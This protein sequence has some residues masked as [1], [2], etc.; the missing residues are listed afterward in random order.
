MNITIYLASAYGNDR[1][2]TEG[3]RQLGKWI[4]EN[5]HTLVYGGSKRGLM[6]EAAESVLDAGGKVIGVEPELFVNQGLLY[7]RIDE[8]IVT[9]DI[10]ERRRKM[11]ELGDAFIAFPGGT[12]TL[13]EISEVISMVCLGQLHAP[14]IL[15]NLNGYYD[16]L[17]RQLQKMIDCGLSSEER[18]A[19]IC[20]ANSVE[21]VIM[22]VEN[23]SKSPQNGVKYSHQRRS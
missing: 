20:F 15:C 14:C 21:E 16:D 7:D 2:F 5:R 17:K 10:S 19:N 13:E 11:I 18:L 3:I 23:A 9:K 1:S 6:G 8:L 22:I 12:G 4:G